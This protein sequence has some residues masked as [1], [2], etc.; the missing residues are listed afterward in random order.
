MWCAALKAIL[1]SHPSG[2]VDPARDATGMVEELLLND[3]IT[4]ERK[5]ERLTEERKKGGTDKVHNERQ[6]ALFQRLHEALSENTPLR[7]VEV[8]SEES[9]ILASFG[10]AH[11]Q[12]A[13][14]RLQPERRAEHALGKPGS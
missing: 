14:D 1:V 2:S 6:T 13:P 9:K 7:K 12:T 10:L 3:L 8:S 11:P 5:L 4:V